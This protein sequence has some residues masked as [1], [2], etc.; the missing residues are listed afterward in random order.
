MNIPIAFPTSQQ[1]DKNGIIK[2]EWMVNNGDYEPL[3]IVSHYKL[4]Q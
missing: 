4:S 3:T 2:L 1:M